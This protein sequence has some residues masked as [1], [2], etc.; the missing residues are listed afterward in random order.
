MTA[1][2]II[3]LLDLVVLEMANNLP[4]PSRLSPD[5]ATSEADRLAAAEWAYVKGIAAGAV[6]RLRDHLDGVRHPS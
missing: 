5:D 2:R 6:L 3:E 1:E 4:M